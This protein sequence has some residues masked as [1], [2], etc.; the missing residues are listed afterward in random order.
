M[1]ALRTPCVFPAALGFLGLK[2]TVPI[3]VASRCGA[4]R[5]LA[6]RTTH[7]HSLA[8]PPTIP[9]TPT[10]A[11]VYNRLT[12]QIHRL[13]RWYHKQ[14]CESTELIQDSVHAT[15]LVRHPTKLNR[16]FVNFDKEI[17]EIIREAKSMQRMGLAIPPIATSLCVQEERYKNNYNALT[18]MLAEYERVTEK[19]TRNLARKSSSN[20]L[21]L[22]FT[23]HVDA[24][25]ARL[26]VLFPP[27][28]IA[29]PLSSSLSLLLLSGGWGGGFRDVG[30]FPF[31]PPLPFPF[32]LSG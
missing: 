3:I 16:L 27:C 21:K 24:I 29:A 25:K 19:I 31:F 15:L 4:F 26:E 13:Q 5:A 6:Y 2:V 14:W 20:N 8:H 9:P 11:Q 10:A 18:F 1:E 28:V 7:S 23:P 17:V 30:G 12:I 32:L 22:L